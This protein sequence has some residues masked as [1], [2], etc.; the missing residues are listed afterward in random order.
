MGKKVTIDADN[1]RI[2]G[3][4]KDNVIEIFEQIMTDKL[5]T[6]SLDDFEKLCRWLESNIVTKDKNA[7][8]DKLF[9]NNIAV[10]MNRN[11]PIGVYLNFNNRRLPKEIK[12]F[13]LA[14]IDAY[15]S[16]LK[17]RKNNAV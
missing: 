7:V 12:V 5:N 8:N 14:V 9:D 2:E 1:F 15:M 11:I 10:I 17:K 3:E 6:P 16:K 13:L 4:I